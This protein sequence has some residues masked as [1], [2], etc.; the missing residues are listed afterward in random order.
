MTVDPTPTET[1]TPRY[2]AVVGPGAATA[3]QV[4]SARALGRGL[5]ERGVVVLTGGHG[6]VMAAAASGVADA[7]G[8]SIAILPGLDR[9]EAD[10]V[11]T[12]ALPTGL[13]E[14]RNGLLVRCADVVV[15][16][17]CSWGTLSEVALAV[18]TGVP[19]VAL[20][21]WELPDGGPHVATSA[22]D[23][24]AQLD[25]LLADPLRR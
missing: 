11:H 3:E 1:A 25:R 18:R 21:C 23:A 7:G 24:L 10:P 13:G 16:V 8:T 22:P 17:G 5:A 19:V 2:A 14:L 4:A 12:F 9:A 15:A 20:D 6:G